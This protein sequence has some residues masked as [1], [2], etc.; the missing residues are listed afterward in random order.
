[1]HKA[2]ELAPTRT[3]LLIQLGNFQAKM[4]NR[5]EARDTFASLAQLDFATIEDLQN[6]A[7]FLSQINEH[8]LATTCLEKGM[9]IDQASTGRHISSVYTSLA[10]E[11][12]EIDDQPSALRTLDQ[13]ISLLPAENSI[14]SLKIDILLGLERTQEALDCID[15]A[16]P[17]T[18]DY[19]FALDLLFTAMR[20]QRTTGNLAGV[21]GYARKAMAQSRAG[22]LTRWPVKILT[23]LAE[24]YRS[25]LQPQQAYLILNNGSYPDPSL[26]ADSQA[27]LDYLCLYT[28]LA[29]ETGEPLKRDI[30]DA[31]VRTD[32]PQLV[33]LMALQARLINKAGNSK[34]AARL[35]QSAVDKANDSTI[36][37]SDGGWER[38][39]FQ[40]MNL[41]ALSEAA[42]EIG[43]WEISIEISQQACQTSSDPLPLLN[44]ARTIVL[45]AEYDQ[46]CDT[47]EVTS[48][49][50][51]EYARTSEN[52]TLAR[53]YLDQAQDLI[54]GFREEP[55]VPDYPLTSDQIFRW[56]ARADII[57][58]LETEPQL[59]P[60]EILARQ[61]SAE[62]TAAL[63]NHLHTGGS[64]HPDSEALTRII[65]L[66]RAFP[67]Q[68][69]VILQIAL[70]LEY[71]NPADAAKSLQSVLAQNPFLKTPTTAFCNYLLARIANSQADSAT[72]CAAIETAIG[73]WND[74]PC[75]H[76]LAAQ[77]YQ[78][79]SDIAHAAEH[80]QVAA[81]LAP[82]DIAYPM[83][84]AKLLLDNAAEDTHLIHQSCHYFESALALQPDE[85][86]ALLGLAEGQYLLSDLENADRNARKALTLAPELGRS[87]QLL[88]EISIRRNDFQGAYEYANKA[89]VASPRDVRSTIVLARSLSALGRHNEAL[90][91]LNAAIPTTIEPELLELER[92]AILSRMEGPRAALN[93]LQALADAHPGKFNILSALAQMYL[94][95]G[96][97]ENAVTSA[98]HALS[99]STEQASRNEQANL[100]LLIGQILRKAGQLDQ[101]IQHLSKAIQLAPDRLEPYLELGLARKERREYQQA[102]QVFE[103]ATQIAPEDPRALFQAGLALKESKDYKSSESMLRRAV[104]LAP[105]DLNIRRQLAAVVALNLVHN[106]RLGRN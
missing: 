102:L 69:G 8:G 64:A 50:P 87:Y 56:Q 66:A 101:A 79:H 30:Q 32:D 31:Q 4:G 35:L 84:L 86:D 7:T 10:H 59:E 92:V 17:Q 43:L 1:M 27:Y 89:M 12:M 36:R 19:V 85:V 60:E 70:A 94:E 47:L 100:H 72:A 13:A 96:E 23:Q 106:P 3:D 48:H 75:W 90:S 97:A 98:Q 6:A 81:R 45:R 29:L 9:A 95:A 55:I 68:P 42:V 2:I 37:I 38:P 83:E 91:R 49:K 44:L 58:N 61:G 40:H 15:A 93:E 16:L 26:S 82:Q 41:V 14:V 34:Q 104:S 51:S 5:D 46:L 103:Q 39:Y 88:G 63:I 22:D 11:Y 57:F 53:Q 62:D 71:S 76:A 99:T 24:L 33:R 20:I 80:W 54:D 28:E 67:R 74:E 77:V 78:G 18:T 65:K 21:A 25:L 105:N 73:F 52:F